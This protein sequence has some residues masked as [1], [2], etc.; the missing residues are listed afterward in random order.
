LG[1][2]I[3]VTFIFYASILPS[4]AQQ[5]KFLVYGDSRGTSASGQINSNILAEI[6]AATTNEAPAFVLVPGDLVF[7]GTNTAFAAWTNIMGPVYQAGIGVYP[8]IG[9]HDDESVSGYTNVFGPYIPDNGPAGEINRTFYFTYSNAL[10]VGLDSYVTAGK[11]NQAWLDGVLASNIMPHVFTF[12]HMPAFKMSHADCL[13]DYP[14][15]RDLFWRSLTNSGSRAY[16]A[17]HDHFYDDARI[18][19][20]DG[21]TNNDIHQFIVGTAGAPLTSNSTYNGSNTV[22]T[23]V[24]QLHEMTNG[25]M[26][27]LINGLDATYIWKHRTAAGT[28][29]AVSTALSYR[30]TP[31]AAR[32]EVAGYSTTGVTLWAEHVTPSASNI[33]EWT[34]NLTSGTWH[35]VAI[36]NTLTNRYQLNLAFTNNQIYYRV[37]SR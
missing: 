28:Y 5:W 1:R 15:D 21:N 17:G 33:V 23:P 7:S 16:F 25:Y 14:A 26:V 29:V 32:L 11:I 13:D 19:D 36:F 2:R 9:N 22:W 12:S 37:K 18:D 31:G 27:V 34:E 6:A 10:I 20:G 4:P 35:S 3:I 8:V 24:R 30:I